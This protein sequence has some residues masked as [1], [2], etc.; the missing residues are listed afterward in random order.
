MKRSSLLL[1]L[2]APVLAAFAA[3]A[4]AQ[5]CAHGNSIYHRKIGGIEVSCSQES[6]HGSD[7]RANKNGILDNGQQAS[8]VQNALDTVADMTATEDD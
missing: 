6:C 1:A 3:A 4:D 8:G 7:P 5:N 2:C